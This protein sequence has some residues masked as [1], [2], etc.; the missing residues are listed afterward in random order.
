VLKAG[1]WN[2]VVLGKR[3]PEVLCIDQIRTTRLTNEP[4]VRPA[5]FQLDQFWRSRAGNAR[6]LRGA[7]G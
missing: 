5:G 2:L 1:S 4:F 3:G 6:S 7:A